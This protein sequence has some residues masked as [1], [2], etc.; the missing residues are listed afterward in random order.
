M[1]E[2]E[3]PLLH[4]EAVEAAPD[5]SEEPDEAGNDPVEGL[6][7]RELAEGVLDGSRKR[8]SHAHHYK[9]KTHSSRI[10]QYRGQLR[11]SA[12]MRLNRRVP[13]GMHGGV[14]GRPLGDEGPPTRLL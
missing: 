2:K 6:Q 8:Y 4:L 13:N 3:I 1:A 11:V 9:Q 7:K 5:E 14:R 10:F 12:L